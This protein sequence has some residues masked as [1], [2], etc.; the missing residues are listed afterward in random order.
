[1]I[2]YLSAGSLENEIST[3]RDISKSQS[4]TFDKSYLNKP[5]N[6]NSIKNELALHC[7]GNENTG[8]L[9]GQEVMQG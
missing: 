7:Y 6:K 4:W 9:N 8:D 5:Y 1:M 3:V 2:F